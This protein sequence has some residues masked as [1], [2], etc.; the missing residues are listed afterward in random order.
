MECYRRRYMWLSHPSSSSTNMKARYCAGRRCSA[1]YVK[2]HVP[3]G[4]AMI[5][6]TQ[7]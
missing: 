5:K 2:P 3:M 4:A 1:V 7:I 6:G